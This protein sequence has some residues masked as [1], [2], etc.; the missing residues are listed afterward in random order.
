MKPILTTKAQVKTDNE[1]LYRER[2]IKIYEEFLF[3]F[4]SGKKEDLVNAIF[5]KGITVAAVESM[6]WV[7]IWISPTERTSTKLAFKDPKIFMKWKEHLM[8]FSNDQKDSSFRVL[9]KLGK[10]KYSTV[11]LIQYKES[12]LLYA[13]KRVLKKD[14]T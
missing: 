13:L 8:K 14:L 9:K 1:L 10:G 6:L 11:F 4:Q 2:T 7:K 5:L 3:I 12:G